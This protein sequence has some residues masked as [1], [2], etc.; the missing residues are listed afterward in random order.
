[1]WLTMKGT[2]RDYREKVR[3]CMK[4][5][6]HEEKRGEERGKGKHFQC[7]TYQGAK[8]N[9]VLNLAEKAAVTQSGGELSN[10]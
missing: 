8:I 4:T 5:G 1:M 10:A 7:C 9:H 6:M 3:P 2:N